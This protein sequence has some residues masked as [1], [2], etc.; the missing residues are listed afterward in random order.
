MNII[1]NEKLNF[2]HLTKQTSLFSCLLFASIYVLSL[3]LWSN[4]NRYNRSDP[5]VIKRRFISVFIT[6]FICLILVYNLS[7]NSENINS[8]F[9]LFEWIGIKFDLFNLCKA[10]FIGILLTCILFAG[11]LVQYLIS[12]L[13]LNF[14]FNEYDNNYYHHHHHHQ[15]TRYST[16]KRLINQFIIEL[17]DL[18]FWRN[19]IVSPFTEE[20]VFRSC[21]LPLLV[22]HF[23]FGYS[24]MIAPLFFG[25]AH[26]HHIIEGYCLNTDPIGFLLIQHLFQFT[27]TYV[28][29]LYSSYLFL[30]TGHLIPSFVSHSFCNFMGVPN[31]AQLLNVFSLKFRMIISFFYVFGLIMFFYFITSFTQPY[32]FENKTYEFIN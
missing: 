2:E 27:Y 4:K 12:S 16:I 10:T 20:F 28:F 9:T 30:R 5:S 25:I 26:L 13:Y 21:M 14:K 17:K 32:L 15:T 22:N 18:T 23:G 7:N 3:Y 1:L 31:L 24:C 19:Y 29:G 8:S 11:P 6:C